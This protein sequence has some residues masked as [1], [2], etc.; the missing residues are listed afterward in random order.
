MDFQTD[1]SGA[2]GLGLQKSQS[3]EVQCQACV[4][5]VQGSLLCF[6]KLREQFFDAG[7][8]IE[9]VNDEACKEDDAHCVRGDNETGVACVPVHHLSPLL[10]IWRLRNFRAVISLLIDVRW[11][12]RNRNV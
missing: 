7:I 1:P 9:G 12:A 4:V 10:A 11:R 8:T 2:Q 5:L 3:A 6:L